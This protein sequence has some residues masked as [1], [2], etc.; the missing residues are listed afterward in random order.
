VFHKALLQICYLRTS[1]DTGELN[2]VSCRRSQ[3][4]QGVSVFNA[5]PFFF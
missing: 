4:K 2:I 3:L 1:A 5:G